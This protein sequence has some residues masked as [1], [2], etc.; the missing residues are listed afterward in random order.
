MFVRIN[1]NARITICIITL[2]IIVVCA[3]TSDYF[4]VNT[5]TM[6]PY[7]GARCVD[8]RANYII[9]YGNIC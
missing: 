9:L 6:S 2:C 5:S 7:L 1:I 8:A 4:I 3:L